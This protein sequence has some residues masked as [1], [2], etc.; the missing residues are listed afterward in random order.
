MPNVSSNVAALFFCVAA[1]VPL[2][3]AVRRFHP[4]HVVQDPF[5]GQRYCTGIVRPCIVLPC[6]ALFLAAA[7]LRIH[8][9]SPALYN[10]A[11]ASR[12]ATQ[13]IVSEGR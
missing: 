8:R 7:F 5:D 1:L 2:L 10:F 13:A 11:L 12:K 9:F 3:T 6:I 4:P